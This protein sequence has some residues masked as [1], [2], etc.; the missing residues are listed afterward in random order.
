MIKVTV[1]FRSVTETRIDSCCDMGVVNFHGHLGKYIYEQETSVCMCCVVKIKQKTQR[2]FDQFSYSFNTQSYL[3][4]VR[5]ATPTIYILMKT[6]LQWH[7]GQTLQ[8]KH[9]I[10]NLQNKGRIAL[11]RKPEK[12]RIKKVKTCVKT[13][14]L[15]A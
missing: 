11:L 3:W 10:F 13:W 5:F 15:I 14:R 1:A 9:I 7:L 8:K 4:M 2:L 12:Q 6:L